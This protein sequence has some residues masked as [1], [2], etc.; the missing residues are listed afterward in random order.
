MRVIYIYIYYIQKFSIDMLR[1]YDWP[2]LHLQRNMRCKH[3]VAGQ[4]M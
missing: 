2:P 1:V 3:N 4:M